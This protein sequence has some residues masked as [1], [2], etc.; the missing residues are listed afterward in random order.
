MIPIEQKK[1]VVFEPYIDDKR[2]NQYLAD[3]YKIFYLPEQNIY[4]DQMFKMAVT[5][6]VSKPFNLY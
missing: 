6:S 2:I 3:D 5:D 1:M 4:N